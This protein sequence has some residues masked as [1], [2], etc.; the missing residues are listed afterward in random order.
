MSKNFQFT[1]DTN[2]QWLDDKNL[3]KHI[4]DIKLI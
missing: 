3:K 2:T 1:S 4:L